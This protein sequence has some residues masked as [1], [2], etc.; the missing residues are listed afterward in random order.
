MNDAEKQK[1][2]NVLGNVTNLEA[3]LSNFSRHS[4]NA[5]KYWA[6]WAK[7]PNRAPQMVAAMK[8]ALT[9]LTKMTKNAKSVNK[10]LVKAA[11]AVK[12]GTTLDKY[13][14]A[15][16]YRDK[17]LAKQLTSARTWDAEAAKFAQ[18]MV[19]VLQMKEY[20]YPKNTGASVDETVT[21][22]SVQHYINY[23]NQMK[24]ALAQC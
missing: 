22:D 7:D 24:V 9:A 6:T 18:K 19:N 23:M 11:M 2:Y 17:V 14:S 5:G 3:Q 8:A 15:K 13:A 4:A 20:K 16:D 1:I 12:N 10:D 21:W